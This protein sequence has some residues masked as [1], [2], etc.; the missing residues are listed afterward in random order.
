MSSEEG[1][2][3]SA[4]RNHETEWEELH[5]SVDCRGAVNDLVSLRELEQRNGVGWPEEEMEPKK[6]LLSDLPIPYLKMTFL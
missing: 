3:Y 6:K 5:A 2:N 4:H 1:G